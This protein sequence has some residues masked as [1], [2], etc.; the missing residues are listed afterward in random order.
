MKQ[1]EERVRQQ[2]QDTAPKM[3]PRV[4][5]YNLQLAR[6]QAQ[7]DMD[8]KVRRA[9]K[10][11]GRLDHMFPEMYQFEQEHGRPPVMPK[12]LKNRY[13]QYRARMEEE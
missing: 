5:Q 10:A 8:M 3:T 7:R 9:R 11:G 1:E 12:A 13:M 2:A 4:Q 6:R